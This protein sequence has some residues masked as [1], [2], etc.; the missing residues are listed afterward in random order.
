[1]LRLSKLALLGYYPEPGE[2]DTRSQLHG[3]TLQMPTFFV[4][5]KADC[6]SLASIVEQFALGFESRAQGLNHIVRC[7]SG[8]LHCGRHGQRPLDALRTVASYVAGCNS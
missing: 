8:A 5:S 3:S 4:T 6:L 1:M 7:L 2:E